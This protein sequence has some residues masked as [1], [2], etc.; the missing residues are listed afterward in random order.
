MP[1][2]LQA[3]DEEESALDLQPVD[4]AA[5]VP[6]IPRMVGIRVP[7]PGPFGQSLEQPGEPAPVFEPVQAAPD[8]ARYPAPPMRPS[9]P[10]IN[11][12]AENFPLPSTFMGHPLPASV[13]EFEGGVSESLAKTSTGLTTPENLATLPA[14]ALPVVGPALMLAQGAKALGAGAGTMIEAIRQRDPRLAGEATVDIGG[15]AAMMLP[16]AVGAAR[17]IRPSRIGQPASIPESEVPSASKIREAKALYGA[18]R[19]PPV[20]GAGKVP[21]EEGGAGVQPQAKE[22]QVP[23]SGELL[24]EHELRGEIVKDALNDL[25]TE[26]RALA[27]S[28]L[29]KLRSGQDRTPQEQQLLERLRDYV[30]KEVERSQSEAEKE[31]TSSAKETEEKGPEVLADQT[32][33]GERAAPPL[34]QQFAGMSVAE[35]APALGEMPKAE[36]DKLLAGYKGNLSEGL[37]GVGYDLGSEART[38]ADVAAL[39]KIHDGY[40][41]Q[42]D[43]AR[44]AGDGNKARHFQRLRQ[45]L[46]EA[47]GAATGVDFAGDPYLG[48]LRRK[49]P[50]Y[51][52]PVP[53]PGYVSPKA[54]TGKSHE[55]IAQELGLLYKHSELP[56]IEPKSTFT[57]PNEGPNYGITFEMPKDATAE[58]IKARFAEKKAESE[59]KAPRVAAPAEAPTVTDE[60]PSGIHEDAPETPSGLPAGVPDRG[61]NFAAELME[62][63]RRLGALVRSKLTLRP[64]VLGMFQ[65]TVEGDKIFTRDIRNQR[66]VAHEIGH[67]LDAVVFAD[68]G[69]L[70]HSQESL[71]QRI[72]TGTK[73]QLYEE[74][75][76]VS[77]LMRGPVRGAYRKRA[78]ELIADWFALYVHDPER[79]RA[80]AP[81]WTGGFE[82][83]LLGNREAREVVDQLIHGNVEPVAPVAKAGSQIPTPEELAGKV[84]ARPAAPAAP[85]EAETA[86]AAQGLVKDAVRT[87]EAENQSARVL[88]DKW[89]RDVPD[90]AQ[91]NDVGGFIEGVGN[92]EKAGDTIEALTKRMTGP[93]KRLAKEYR[94][95]TELLRQRINEYLKGTE[96]GEYLA[97]LEDYLG[98]FYANGRTAIRSALGRFIKESPHAKQRVIP[99]LKEAVDMGL[100]PLTQNPL[101]TYEL[102]ARI[103]WR[104]ATN[105]KFVAKMKDLKGKDGS[106]M[107]VP[108]KDAPPGWPISNNPLIQRVYARQ[109]PGGVLLW[110]GGAAIHPDVWRAARQILETPTSSDLGRLYDAVNSVSRSVVLFMTGFHDLTLRSAALGKG[111]FEGLQVGNPLRGLVRFMERNP[112]TGEREWVRSTRTLG[113]Q[114]MQNEQIVTD[115]AQDGLKMAWTDSEAYQKNARDLLERT[116][117]RTRDIPYVGKSVRFL[118]DLQ[119]MRAKGLWK[120]THDAYKTVAAYDA[121]A[122]ALQVAPEGTD[123]KLVRE[124]VASLLNDAYGGQEWQTHFW[125]SPVFRKWYARAMMFP[126]WTLSTIRSVPGASDVAALAREQAPRL[127]GREPLPTPKEGAFGNVERA[128]FWGGELAGLAIATLAAQYA[129]YTAFGRKEQGDQAWVWDNEYKNRTRV[130]VTPIMRQMPWA[131]PKDK[132]RHYVNLG[133]R[134]EEILRW[135]TTPDQQIESKAGRLVANL[136]AQLTGTEGD[137]KAEWKRDHEAFLESVPARLKSVAKQF[138]PFSL[139]GNQ[140]VLSLPMRKG[141]TKYKAQQAY[142]SMYEVA[143]NPSS[144]R[145]M[146]RGQPASEGT[147]KSMV[148]QITDAAK[149]NGVEAEKVRVRA[150]SVVK[151]HHYDLFL[152]AA[153]K[154]DF[155][156]MENEAAALARLQVPNIGESMSRSVQQK[157]VKLTPEQWGQMGKAITSGRAK[158]HPATNAP[159]DLQPAP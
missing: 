25:P 109:T 6:D 45:V 77:E 56:G 116:A 79:A 50:D 129:I 135:F 29:E 13:R 53:A 121:M 81:N 94:Y 148:A 82:D 69:A 159:L 120:N 32:A 139:S 136:L 158:A 7:T 104:V 40:K 38:A 128:K 70:A 48:N 62:A 75:R 110:R 36:F 61:P 52:P 115:L 124:R 35:I 60:W 114:M 10:L 107:V 65:R 23:P 91:Q 123:P 87:V 42:F 43:A 138:I 54:A 4:E 63:S 73:K 44:A 28:A 18:V 27:N 1:L 147:L 96:D 92:L 143:A 76:A 39:K 134:P 74:L 85:R 113:K 154:D 46:K 150:L 20:E 16:G 93:M 86:V 19:P 155:K 78:S 68:S 141:M 156:A 125:M 100:T 105:R 12:T 95:R 106:P 131:D 98:H 64:N 2:D 101:R 83:K 41:A 99:T 37:T 30:N 51:E 142:E 72:G 90:P 8:L 26:D 66:T 130:D 151:G 9:E 132:T 59:A 31:V 127:A 145:A 112:L 57:D 119:E 117:A 34:S 58:Q 133:K 152:K 24:T 137:F 102:T 47:Y 118:R 89:S 111:F 146:L 122:K 80:M 17:A 84:P 67:A 55:Q 33:A 49:A 126:D 11:F 21:A 5:P 149:A 22:G 144:I 15:G 14:Y 71:V 103:N 3:V 153:Q 88:T 140:F 97:F 108:A 157:G